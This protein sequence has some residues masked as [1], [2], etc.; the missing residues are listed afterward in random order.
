[1]VTIVD[2][3]KAHK[4]ISDFIFETPC[5]FSEDLSK[6][7]GA[8][9]FL[10]LDNMQRTG[11]F[12]ERGALARLLLLD[13]QE[14]AKGVV[15]AS[16]GNHGQAVA[17]HASRLGIPAQVFMPLN[18]PAIKISRTENYGAKIHLGGDNYDDAHQAALLF[19]EKTG[20]FYLHAYDD[21][22]VISGQGTV[23]LE[24]KK[25][26]PN[27]DMVIVPVGGGGLISGIAVAMKALS[28]Q[29]Q[30]I[31]VEPSVMPSMAKAI[32]AKGPV[33]LLTAH[34]I[35]DGIRVRLVGK[36][37]YAICAHLVS[38]WIS[39]DDD[40]IARA[41][42]FLLEQQKT[43]AEGAGAAGVAALL[44]RKIPSIRNKCICVLVCGGNI[45]VYTLTRV[46]ERGMVESGRLVRLTVKIKDHPGELQSLLEV[47]SHSQANVLEIRHE[48]AFV[49]T[50]WSDVEV[51]LVLETRGK[52]HVVEILSLM[53]TKGYVV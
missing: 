48:R 33:K 2:I 46:I 52:N 34:T 10:K 15:T 43:C 50:I 9:V 5:I 3:E 11:S 29:T 16:A 41:I 17:Y 20:A 40:Q 18:S 26:L 23:A 12:K 32:A 4:R 31:G 44:D 13:T 28:P 30:V 37:T 24:I 19:A 35:A 38:N 7:T 6:I 8:S 53:R 36:L 47:I 22:A 51:N 1:M 14:R 27:T 25:Q 42:L 49:H 45:D 39:V 21:A